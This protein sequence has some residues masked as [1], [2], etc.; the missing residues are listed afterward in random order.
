TAVFAFV[1][2]LIYFNINKIKHLLPKKKW[3]KPLRKYLLVYTLYDTNDLGRILTIS[4]LRYLVFCSQFLLLLYV[5]GVEVPLVQS[6]FM[7][8]L[9]YLVQTAVPTTALTEIGV[10]G[11]VSVYFFNYYTAN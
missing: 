9:M 4:L 8:L 3:L 1:S 7:V 6:F 5:F 10:R 11:A 2:A